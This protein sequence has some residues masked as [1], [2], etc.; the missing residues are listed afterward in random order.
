MNV[1]ICS[2]KKRKQQQQQQQQNANRWRSVC[3]RSSS[4]DTGNRLILQ[5]EITSACLLC[6]K[7]CNAWGWKA[8]KTIQFFKSTHIKRIKSISIFICLLLYHFNSFYIL[9]VLTFDFLGNVLLSK[10]YTWRRFL[11]YFKRK[12]GWGIIWNDGIKKTL[13]S[14]EKECLFREERNS[15]W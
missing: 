1:T 14:F 3:I 12:G 6:L 9:F 8:P 13:S 4:S 10:F 15:D 5:S 2:L 11:L 7:S